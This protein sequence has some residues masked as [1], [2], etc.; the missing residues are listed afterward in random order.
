[1]CTYTHFGNK[2]STGIYSKQQGTGTHTR[3]QKV[4]PNKQKNAF[5]IAF[6]EK[7]RKKLPLQS[8]CGRHIHI[9]VNE[10]KPVANITSSSSLCWAMVRLARSLCILSCPA[11]PFVC[12]VH[13]T[14][15]ETQLNQASTTIIIFWDFSLQRSS[16]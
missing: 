12:S 9:H 6:H 1:M 8:L 16:R 4:K 3:R 14:R 10:E 15:I 2:L 11:L 7:R 5:C 13:F